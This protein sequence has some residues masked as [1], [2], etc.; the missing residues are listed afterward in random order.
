MAVDHRGQLLVWLEPLPL[1]ARTP[2]L[3]EAPCPALWTPERIRR[4]A[5]DIGM[6]PTE[7]RN[8]CSG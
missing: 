3:E 1:E 4:Q 6:M 5:G 2:V 7:A 8:P